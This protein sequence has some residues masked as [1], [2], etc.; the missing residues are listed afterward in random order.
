MKTFAILLFPMWLWTTATFASDSQLQTEI[1]Y[2]INKVENSHCQFI[3]NGDTH[4]GIDAAEHM[5]NKYDYFE[6]E[7]HTAE[8]FIRQ[9]ASK[10]TITGKPYEVKCANSHLTSQQWL[11]RQLEA[12]RQNRSSQ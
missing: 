5:L 7:I 6:D 11:L 2:L 10:S 12:F 8:D 9:A 4:S 1:R 3:R